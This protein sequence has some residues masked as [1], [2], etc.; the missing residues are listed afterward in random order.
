M[1]DPN[2]VLKQLSLIT[3]IAICTLPLVAM[4][5]ARYIT[6]RNQD[7]WAQEDAAL[8]IVAFHLQHQRFP[9]GW[10]EAVACYPQQSHG[11]QLTPEATKPRIIIDFDHPPGVPDATIHLD[12]ESR[13]VQYITLRNGPGELG[14]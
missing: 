5:G 9:S 7:A 3:V 10:E 8:M 6:G 2:G 13:P 11:G 12:H 1:D 4:Q 14:G